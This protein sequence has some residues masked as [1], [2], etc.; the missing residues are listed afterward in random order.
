M[1][2]KTK[3]RFYD[4]AAKGLCGN[5]PMTWASV[6]EAL[7]SD[8]QWFGIR[9]LIPDHSQFSTA[10]PRIYL[11]YVYFDFLRYD[12]HYIITESDGIQDHD[13]I[14]GLQGELTWYA[15]EWRLYH[16]HRLGNM[17]HRLRETGQTAS[18]WHAL[19]LLK[20]H[21]DPVDYDDLMDLFDRYSEGTEYPVIEFATTPRP[22]GRLHRH[23]VIWEIRSY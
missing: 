3:S 10:V 2:I 1:L 4:L 14:Y 16:T 13:Q 23:I 9:W 15:G 7:D 8:C 20:T 22:M 11:R 18:G 12:G 21:L 5:T 6:E 19:E 17:R